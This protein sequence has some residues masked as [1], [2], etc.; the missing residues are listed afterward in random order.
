MPSLG[1]TKALLESYPKAI[2]MEEDLASRGL[3]D[4][5][6]RGALARAYGQL[7]L[8]YRA[9]GDKKRAVDA[10]EQHGLAHA[11]LV[12]EDEAATAYLHL[13]LAQ[14]EA[15]QPLPA[16]QAVETALPI[17]ING[18]AR[19]ASF[20]PDHEALAS[21]YALQ[22]GA[23]A[24]L[25]RLDEAEEAALQAIA[26]R[27]PRLAEPMLNPSNARE[28]ILYYHRAADLLGSNDRFNLGRPAEAE[29]YYRKALAVAERLAATDPNNV[30]ARTEVA[31]SIGKLGMVLEESN[32]AETLHLY[33][34]AQQILSSLPQGAQ[35]EAL[36]GTLQDSTTWP[37]ATLGRTAEVRQL[38][39]PE[40]W[41]A[42]LAKKPGDPEAIDNLRDAW[43]ALAYC[44]R[45]DTGVSIGYY[46]K[47]LSYA[48]LGAETQPAGI[49]R[50]RIHME[51]LQY[52]TAELE[53]AG[54]AAAEVRPFASE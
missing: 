14:M 3:L 9:N 52:L 30:T 51:V 54:G 45:R 33:Q 35:R 13:G 46:R 16:L 48:D 34:R 41:E 20:G 40:H 4:S 42:Q 25:L 11:R 15:G 21:L 12:S 8:G 17:K 43:E 18:A 26:I 44:E 27:E 50:T 5:A 37:L 2:A 28:L 22:A 53:K 23:A 38:V 36:Q 10:A 39:Q 32:A 24:L 29:A 49:P 1:R 31:R 19:E 7:E 47:A 6:K